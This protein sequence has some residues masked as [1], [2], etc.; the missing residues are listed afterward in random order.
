MKNGLNRISIL[1]AGV[2]CWGV[3]AAHSALAATAGH[4]HDVSVPGAEGHAEAGHAASG[5]GLPQL[6]ATTFPSQLFWLAI[7]FAILY[8]IFSKKALPGIS[9]FMENRQNHSR[10]DMEIAE[11][12]KDDASTA[13]KAYEDSLQNARDEALQ[14][15]QLIQEKI[16]TKAEKQAE[17]FRQKADKEMQECERNLLAA[18]EEA[19]DDMNMIAAEIAS[20]AAKKIVGI[21]PDIEQAKTVVK[22]LSNYTKAKAA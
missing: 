1:S 16:K 4:G 13:Q 8:L 21:N 19:M 10:G 9:G 7:A 14:V 15:M 12:L 5:G 11:K 20:E 17:S 3:V 18:K 2:F 22:S 6:D